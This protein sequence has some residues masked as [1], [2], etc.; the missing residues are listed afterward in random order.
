[1]GL[2]QLYSQDTCRKTGFAGIPSRVTYLIHISS[3]STPQC[4]N[5]ENYQK[6]IQRLW[7]SQSLSQY[8]VVQVTKA[9]ICY[10]YLICTVAQR[11][12]ILKKNFN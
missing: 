5:E 12:C 11:T 3:L 9:T 10:C 8:S 6:N 1:M 4:T 2:L 7:K